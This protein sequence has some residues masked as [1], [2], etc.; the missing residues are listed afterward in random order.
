L[1]WIKRIKKKEEDLIM[2]TYRVTVDGQ[3]YEVTV[4]EVQ[5]PEI[6]PPRMTAPV[7][8]PPPAQAPVATPK[9]TPKPAVSP[10]LSTPAPAP[11][12]KPVPVPVV[13]EG[14]KSV[15]APMP[16]KILVVNVAPGAVVK[17]GAVLL[18]LEAMKMENDIMAPVDGTIK[19]VNVSV[20]S[21]VNTGDV[22][23]VIE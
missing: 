18:I 13:G 12:P 16:G 8:P 15:Q 3:V 6:I 11:T 10:P 14:G 21:S 5:T 9:V 23:V 1:K 17:R 2:K 22:L 7:P 4:E 20:G 19:A